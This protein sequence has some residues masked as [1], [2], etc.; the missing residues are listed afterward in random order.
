M[1]LLFITDED[2]I[3]KMQK[4]IASG[5][6][7]S[8][9]CQERLNALGYAI[10]GCHAFKGGKAVKQKLHLRYYGRDLLLP[11]LEGRAKE[12]YLENPQYF[13]PGIGA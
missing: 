3:K 8:S 4:I 1:S 6:L 11:R 9:S 7:P 5:V 13:F 2:F 12:I 10:C